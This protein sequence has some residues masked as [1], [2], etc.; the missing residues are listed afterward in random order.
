MKQQ[1]KGFVSG[2]FVSIVVCC[3]LGTA[4]AAYQK[5]ATLNYDGIAIT[6]DGEK[7]T[8]KDANGNA[9]EPFIVDGTTYLPVRAIGDALGLNVNW[10]AATKTVK[11][12]YGDCYYPDECYLDFSV[13]TLDNLVGFDAYVD[14]ATLSD[15]SIVYIYDPSK[16]Q[17]ES[18]WTYA[19]AYGALLNEY[20]FEYVNA[21]KDDSGNTLYS[22]YHSENQF[23]IFYMT[24]FSQ[25]PARVFVN[26][27]RIAPS[28][29]N[30]FNTNTNQDNV[31][32]HESNLSVLKKQYEDSIDRLDEKIADAKDEIISCQSE[33]SRLPAQKESLKS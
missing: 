22:Y 16:F 5:Q 27:G 33:R 6:L 24:D 30:S 2:I 31:V 25:S 23:F 4:M 18:L 32:A 3:L 12:E 15:G 20:G 17:Y 21:E 26:V 19:N 14:L 8:P 10:D 9:V 11:M 1:W 29:V 13:P 28:D 7:V